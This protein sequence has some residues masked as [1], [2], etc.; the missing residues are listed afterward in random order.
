MPKSVP[1]AIARVTLS[2]PT[3]KPGYV[4]EAA[5]VI[6]AII[7]SPHADPIELAYVAS[8]L[9]DLGPGYVD[10]AVGALCAVIADSHIGGQ[11]YAAGLL[12]SLGPGYVPEAAQAIRAALTAQTTVAAM[13]IS[14]HL[15]A[16]HS[17]LPR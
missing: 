12:A 4:P 5:Q 14:T 15:P 13:S 17:A 11:A 3:L 16:E 9:P 1:S 2:R 7:T 8:D 6:R 10:E